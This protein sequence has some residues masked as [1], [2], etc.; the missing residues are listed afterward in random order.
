M[1]VHTVPTVPTTIFQSVPIIWSNDELSAALIYRHGCP[2]V[3]HNFPQDIRGRSEAGKAGSH[4]V[5]RGT[6]LM[7]KITDLNKSAEG[8]VR[9]GSPP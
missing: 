9:L 3:L 4:T 8:P 2:A 5:C 6:S 1:T 7:L